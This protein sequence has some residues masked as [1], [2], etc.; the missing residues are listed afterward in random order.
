MRHAFFFL[1][2]NNKLQITDIGRPTYHFLQIEGWVMVVSHFEREDENA[3]WLI[4]NLFKADGN[5]KLDYMKNRL[6]LPGL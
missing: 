4:S 3:G 5:A 6:R 1:I 2:K